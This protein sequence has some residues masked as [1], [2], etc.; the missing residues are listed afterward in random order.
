M[1]HIDFA[2]LQTEES[3]EGQELQETSLKFHLLIQAFFSSSNIHILRMTV[4]HKTR[5]ATK[6]Q[7]FLFFVFSIFIC[8]TINS[9]NYMKGKLICT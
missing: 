6:L 7:R 8:T 9:L 2:V 3:Y 4:F 1:S 5:Q